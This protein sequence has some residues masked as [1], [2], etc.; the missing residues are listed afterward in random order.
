MNKELTATTT[1]SF[2]SMGFIVFIVLLVLKLTGTINIAWF[3]VW[4][5]FWLPY[6][7]AGFF[8]LLLLIVGII[9]KKKGY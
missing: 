5:P 7:I 4:F 8:L 6:A 3:W 1:I 9:L 2:A